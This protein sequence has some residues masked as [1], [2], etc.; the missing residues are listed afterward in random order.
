MIWFTS[1]THY[2][3]KN[4]CKG[5]SEWKGSDEQLRKFD[6]LEEMNSCILKG[7][8]DNVKED[9]ELYH[10][11][12]WSFGGIQNIWEFRK[13]IEC[14]NIHLIYGNHDQH[15]ENN[16]VLSNCYF[17]WKNPKEILSGDI[18]E[19]IDYDYSWGST[20]S[21]EVHAQDLFSSVQYY[22]EL[23]IKGYPLIILSHYAFRVWNKSHHQSIMLFGHSHGTLPEYGLH[24]GIRLDESMKYKTMDVGI[25]NIFKLK[26]EYRPISLLEVI[27][28]MKD[29]VNLVIDHHNE[30]TN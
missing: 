19:H 3:H 6:T 12:D 21:N 29:R 8:N 7:I 4:I 13:Q 26:G 10:L 11:G 14:K 16:K 18:K 25:D 1:D 24:S 23:K 20:D 15:I 27:E 30:N 28:I 2:A 5:T 22:K 17:K 9:D